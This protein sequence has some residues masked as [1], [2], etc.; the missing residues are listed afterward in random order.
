MGVF[1]TFLLLSIIDKNNVFVSW[2]LSHPEAEYAFMKNK[3]IIPLKLQKGYTPDG[4]LGIIQGSKYFYDFTKEDRL[5]EKRL[6]LLE[7]VRKAFAAQ[8]G[9]ATGD[10]KQVCGGSID[11]I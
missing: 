2:L 1:Q 11:I 4:W 5:E 6:Q 7:A 3:H 8:A 10:A 9:G